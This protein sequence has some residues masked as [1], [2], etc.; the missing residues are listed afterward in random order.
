MFRWSAVNRPTAN[1][2]HF[3]VALIRLKT[4]NLGERTIPNF[5]SSQLYNEQ[6]GGLP[7]DFGGT[8][9]VKN[10]LIKVGDSSRWRC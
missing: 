4:H 2:G 3:H 7:I 8:F 1:E 6:V 5:R 9:Y 10:C